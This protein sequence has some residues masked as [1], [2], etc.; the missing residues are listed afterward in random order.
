VNAQP[1]QYGIVWTHGVGQSR[2]AWFIRT[3]PRLLQMFTE[4]WRTS[5]LIASFEGFSFLPPTS[6][7]ASWR[8]AEAWFHTDQN[9]RTRPGLQTIQSFTSLYDQ[10]ETTGAFVVV[11]RSWRQHAEVTGRIYQGTNPPDDD[12]QFLMLPPNDPV[13]L[14]PRQPHLIRVRAGDAVLWDSRTVHC[15][16][17]SLRRSSTSGDSAEPTKRRPARVVVYG[18]F[19]PRQRAADKVLLARQRAAASQRTCTHWPFD[20]SCLDVP[21]AYG[22]RPSDPLLDFGPLERQLIGRTEGQRRLAEANGDENP[23]PDEALACPSAVRFEAPQIT[24]GVV[25]AGEHEKQ[26]CKADAP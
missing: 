25:E 26:S 4:F 2:L 17:P 16:T 12:Q 9:A 8:L 24:K 20:M 13:L 18:S 10:D 23:A 19:V 14:A 3:R 11:P 15:S 1:N 7:E 5:D 6:A 21:R 22:E